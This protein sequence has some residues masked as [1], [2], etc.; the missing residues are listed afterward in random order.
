[1]FS[2]QDGAITETSLDFKLSS[3]D[4]S[5]CTDCIC[6]GE[7]PEKWSGKQE[8]SS[9]SRL[10]CRAFS[11]P[12][13][14]PAK[15]QRSQFHFSL[16]PKDLHVVVTVLAVG[17]KSV[18]RIQKGFQQKEKLLIRVFVGGQGEL[19]GAQGELVEERLLGLC[20]AKRL[21]AAA[22]SSTDSNASNS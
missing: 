13:V 16:F 21:G 10:I 2:M 5:F 3:Q 9:R 1:M 20:L 14:S 8:Y 6:H 19:V 18:C 15:C 22:I 4:T 12:W 11:L 17:G 7:T